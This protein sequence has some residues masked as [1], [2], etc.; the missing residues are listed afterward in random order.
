[1]TSVKYTETI[2]GP[3][4]VVIVWLFALTPTGCGH[5]ASEVAA[6]SSP[7]EP[8]SV[9]HAHYAHLFGK[10]YRTKVDLYLFS[11]TSEPDYK[12]LGRSTGSKFLSASLPADVSRRNVGRTYG[13]IK[14][15]DVVPG[16]SELTIR[17]ETHEVTPF[18]G[19]QG[20]A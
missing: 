20:S 5:Q 10:R 11:L 2:L 6:I 12:Y 3:L 14:I 13:T 1:M 17:A 15:L 8:P 9:S 7:A 4:S 19:V 16:G 18:S